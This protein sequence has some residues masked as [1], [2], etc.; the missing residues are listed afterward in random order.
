[1]WIVNRASNTTF[2]AGA[3]ALIATLLTACDRQT[4][5]KGAP[6]VSEVQTSEWLAPGCQRADDCAS[7]TV[8]R[9]VFADQP[10]LN[11]AIR[12]GLLEQLQG[13]GESLAAGSSDSLEQVAEEFLQQASKAAEISRARWQLSGEASKLARRGNTLTVAIRSY[14]YSGGAHG[15]PA[16]HWL[17]WDLAADKALALT[18]ILQPGQAQLFWKRAEDAHRSWQASQNLGA[19]FGENW[20]FTRSDDFRLTDAGITLLYGVYSIA[21][22]SM[23][24][25][26]L[27]VP[28][29]RLGDVVRA[30]YRPERSTK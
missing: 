3:V 22:Y 11:A 9:E 20:P 4:D 21:P 17:N 2:V 1:M 29:D 12:R 16:T 6:L 26:E 15:L 14:M 19:D 10:G 5:A 13:N 18:D 28:W 25:V 8:K 27:T 23:G 24:E 30:E 7:V